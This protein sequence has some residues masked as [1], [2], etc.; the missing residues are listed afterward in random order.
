MSTQ[1]SSRDLYV[2]MEGNKVAGIYQY[3][4]DAK[5]HALACGGNVI[6]QQ[7]RLEIPTWVRTMNDSA[8]EKAKQ[9]GGSAFVGKR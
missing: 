8:M 5:A 1:T 7:L 6:V 2:V 4:E 3:R 9:Q